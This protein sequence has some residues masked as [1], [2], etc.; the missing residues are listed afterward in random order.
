M[1]Y[2]NVL[3]IVETTCTA[4]TQQFTSTQHST[5]IHS[6]RHSLSTRIQN[7]CKVNG[8]FT[9]SRSDSFSDAELSELITA[10]LIFLRFDILVGLIT[11]MGR[12]RS[13]SEAV[14]TFTKQFQS[15]RSEV[16][17]YFVIYLFQL[18]LAQALCLPRVRLRT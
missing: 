18:R 7:V 15:Q 10:L 17:M 1:N 3:I 9:S 12:T 2:G 5:G 4:Q 11:Q 13:Q 8:E 6:H 16:E 14:I